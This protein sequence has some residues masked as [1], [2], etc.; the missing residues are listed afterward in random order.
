MAI[1]WQLSPLQR[2]QLGRPGD[3]CPSPSVA[4]AIIIPIHALLLQNDISRS[5][6]YFISFISIFKTYKLPHFPN[7]RLVINPSYSL[8]FHSYEY[9]NPFLM[10]C[11]TLHATQWSL[12]QNTAL[13]VLYVIYH[14]HYSKTVSL[15]FF[16]LLLKYGI[17]Y[18]IKCTGIVDIAG[19][20][21][22]YV[23]K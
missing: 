5:Y 12:K 7:N 13:N 10:R 23:V 4:V 14:H 1:V 16:A 22:L 21:Y 6:E 3:R 20:Q 8:A 9:V 17:K 19:F 15:G 18:G 2:R 11:C